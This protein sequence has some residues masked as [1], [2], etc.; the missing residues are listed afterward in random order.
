MRRTILAAVLILTSLI[1]ACRRVKLTVVSEP[2]PMRQV[3]YLHPDAADGDLLCLPDSSMLKDC[4]TVGEIRNILRS[5][6]T[7]P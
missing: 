6:K 5:V 1:V 4:R 7:V 3:W 2:V